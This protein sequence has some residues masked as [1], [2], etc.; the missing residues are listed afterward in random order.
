[1]LHGPLKYAAGCYMNEWDT[2]W[3][4]LK[5]VHSLRA[6]AMSLLC[7]DLQFKE[8]ASCLPGCCL[9]TASAK[10]TDLTGCSSRSDVQYRC[11]SGRRSL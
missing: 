4:L 1:M 5:Y 7:T 11:Q 9:Q 10:G 3:L 8:H 6:D 2:C